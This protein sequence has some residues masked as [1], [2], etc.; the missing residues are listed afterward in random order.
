MTNLLPQL[1]HSLPK[2]FGFYTMA[3][4]TH[5]RLDDKL[6]HEHLLQDGSIHHLQRQGY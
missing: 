5:L 3:V 4:I 6:H 2:V 1:D